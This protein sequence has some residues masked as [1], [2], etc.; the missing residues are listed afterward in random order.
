ML[1]YSYIASYN[2]DFKWLKKIKKRWRKLGERRE[3]KVLYGK[4]LAKLDVDR[5]VKVVTD[6]L[7][8]D[9][10]RMVEEYLLLRSKYE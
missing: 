7:R 1:V 9:G 6:K 5:L 8:I 3:K 2:I 4:R 10:D